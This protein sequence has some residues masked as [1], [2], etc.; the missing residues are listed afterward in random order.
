MKRIKSIKEARIDLSGI[1]WKHFTKEDDIQF[2]N[3]V[4]K[5]LTLTNWT[6]VTLYGEPAIRFD[7]LKEDKTP[8]KKMLT[9]K[10]RRLIRKLKPLMTK[11]FDKGNPTIEVAITR[12]GEGYDTDYHVRKVSPNPTE[13]EA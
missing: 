9:T 1:N 8:V 11:A 7:V 5:E 3:D 6:Q 10:S 12:T 2:Q 4:E 13:D